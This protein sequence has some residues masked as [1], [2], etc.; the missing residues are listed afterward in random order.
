MREI[1][2][3]GI[4][5]KYLPDG[6]CLVSVVCVVEV[7]VCGLSM[8]GHSAFPV[9]CEQ[10]VGCCVSGVCVLCVGMRWRGSGVPRVARAGR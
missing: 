1:A 10:S 9:L 4:A 5:T 7:C 6:L 3:A 8:S 2:G